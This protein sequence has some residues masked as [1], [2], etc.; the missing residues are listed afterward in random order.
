MA[1]EILH[2][3]SV[4]GSPLLDRKGERIGRVEDLVVRATGAAHPPVGGLVVRIGGRELFVPIE[5]VWEIRPHQVQLQGQKLNLSRFERRAGELLLARDLSARHLINVVGA[6]LIRANEIELALVDNTW[7]V[8]G[9][10]PSSRG[11]IRRIL[12]RSL[13]NKIAPGGI[14]DWESIEPFVSHIPSARMRIPYRK[15]AKLRAAQIADLVEA[16]SHDEGREIIEAVGLNSE[17]EA[18]VFEELDEEHQ[19]EFLDARTNEEAGRL[20]ARM[21]PD[22]AVDL[23]NDLDQERRIPILEAM[24]APQQAKLRRLLN[25]NPETAGGLMSPDFLALNRETLVSQ[26]LEA[27]RTSAVADEILVTIYELDGEDRLTGT[28]SVVRLLKAN[29]SAKLEDI[30]ERDPVS[31][32]A[33]ADIHEIVRKMA[34]FNLS[35]LPVVD[36]ELRIIGV[37]TFDDVLE[38]MIPTGWRREFGMTTL[39]D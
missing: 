3:S 7:Q 17:L 10:D 28:V 32:S 29:P 36:N 5:L 39:E 9:V 8:V 1:P 12:P 15:L 14:V 34:D 27:L 16:A 30:A 2:L 11:A 33:D 18:D 35:N 6:R 22:D 13:G 23:L 31:I 20:L 25:Y 21:E 24:P 4:T 37:I 19:V 26:S 38:E